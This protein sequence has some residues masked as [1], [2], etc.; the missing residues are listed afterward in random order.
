MDWM[1]L[2]LAWAD[3]GVVSELPGGAFKLY[4]AAN[5]LSFR[6][7]SDGFVPLAAWDRLAPGTGRRSQTELLLKAG[8]IEEVPDSDGVLLGYALIPYLD[9]Q[10][11]SDERARK[12]GDQRDRTAKARAKAKAQHHLRGLA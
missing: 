9:Q 4:V 6:Q 3:D 10:M 2:P 11:S 5:I 12:T 7:N 1:K 8:L